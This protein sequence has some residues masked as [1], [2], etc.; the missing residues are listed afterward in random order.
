L[1]LNERKRRRQRGRTKHV[2]FKS[3]KGK[4]VTTQAGSQGRQES[5][6]VASPSPMKKEILGRNG[7]SGRSST[8][9]CSNNV[10]ERHQT[11]P[12][13]TKGEDELEWRETWKAGGEPC[14]APPYGKRGGGGNARSLEDPA[15]IQER[16]KKSEHQNLVKG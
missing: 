3:I 8:D 7:H 13:L 1:K 10:L 14:A 16:K 11:L 15:A 5:N 2:L 9:G 12:F 6:R 4:R